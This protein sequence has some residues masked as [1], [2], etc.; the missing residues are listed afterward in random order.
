MSLQII[1]GLI[2]KDG[3][4]KHQGKFRTKTYGGVVVVVEES[5]DLIFGCPLYSD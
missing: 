2:Q 3:Q 1:L 4:N 5:R